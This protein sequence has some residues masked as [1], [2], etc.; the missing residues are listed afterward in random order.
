[1]QITA[2]IRRNLSVGVAGGKA[3]TLLARLNQMGS[4]NLEAARRRKAAAFPDEKLRCEAQAPWIGNLQGRKVLRR[5]FLS[6]EKTL[7]SKLPLIRNVS[8]R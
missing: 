7:Y 8:F 2:Q 4:G 5:G 3:E 6:H 1:M